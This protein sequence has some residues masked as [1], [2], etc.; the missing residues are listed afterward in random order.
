MRV[1]ADWLFT[2]TLIEAVPCS[3]SRGCMATLPSC[4][5]CSIYSIA[6]LLTLVSTNTCPAQPFWRDVSPIGPDDC[7]TIAVTPAGDIFVGMGAYTSYSRGVLRSTDQGTT[8]QVH[9]LQTARIEDLIIHPNGNVY[10]AENYPPGVHASSDNGSTWTTL[11]QAPIW[12]SLWKLAINDQGY[13]FLAASNGVY[14]STDLGTTWVQANGGIA[15]TVLRSVYASSANILYSRSH[16]GTLYRSTTNGSSWIDIT[17][18]SS[19]VGAFSELPPST[20]LAASYGTSSLLYRSTNNGESW[21]VR[22]S[23]L[24]GR[25]V[26]NMVTNNT[27]A[28]LAVTD[29]GSWRFNGTQWSKVVP[30]PYGANRLVWYS[31]TGTVWSAGDAGVSISSSMGDS[32]RLARSLRHTYVLATAATPI[33]DVFAATNIKAIFRSTDQGYSWRIL[34]YSP[35]ID[36]TQ[37]LITNKEGHLYAGSN[38]GGILRSTT[39][40]ESWDSLFSTGTA[41]TYRTIALGDSGLI[42]TSTTHGTFRSTDGGLTWSLATAVSSRALLITSL[43]TV[44]LGNDN[45]AVVNR[46]TDRGTTWTTIQVGTSLFNGISS[47]LESPAGKL[48]AGRGDGRTYHSTDDGLSWIRAD[49]IDLPS[50]VTQLFSVSENTLLASLPSSGTYRT[51]DGGVHWEEWGAGIPDP[52][53][54]WGFSMDTYGY[55]YAGSTEGIA[56]TI[57]PVTSVSNA[58]VPLHSFSLRQN[59]PN[60]F[61]PT[62]VIVFALPEQMKVSLRLYNMLGQEIRTLRDEVFDR[63]E[64]LVHLSSIGL[65]SGVYMYTL[66]GSNHLEMKKLLILK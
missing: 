6:L 7:R 38:P 20:I 62:T 65:A 27:G 50:S 36:H 55:V 8:W 42:L 58:R 44:L 63:G 52:T 53:Q 57:R 22:D 15:D 2:T 48:L 60:P 33:G 18:P 30:P 54:V 24:I 19:S 25:R 12:V 3:Q 56:R 61:N 11:W 43:N 45:Q 47:L 49:S 39:S 10:A 46:S 13:I 59:Y 64:H 5:L 26:Y 16:T 14:R 66:E 9:G 4:R 28:I 17:P 41:T 31:A 1:C 35:W 37:S 29:D 34:P 32:W 51:T 21:F 23:S 40:G